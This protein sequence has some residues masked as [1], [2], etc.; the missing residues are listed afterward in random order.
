MPR[1]LPMVSLPQPSP[2][3]SAPHPTTAA[4]LS[5]PLGCHSTVVSA[6]AGP[7]FHSGH[8]L[9]IKPPPATLWALP[10]HVDV[11]HC[12]PARV[13]PQMKGSTQLDIA[14]ERG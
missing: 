8:T 5:R 14:V 11:R 10:L 13:G 9:V 3:P 2:C 6:A 4:L 1:A 12:S 7:R